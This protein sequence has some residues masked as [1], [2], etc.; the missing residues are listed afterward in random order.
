MVFGR[1]P[2]GSGT[3]LAALSLLAAPVA[4]AEP[5][6]FRRD[7]TPLPSAVSHPASSDAAQIAG[8]G[9]VLLRTLVGLVIVVALIYGVYWLLKTYAGSK[10]GKS[11]GRMDIV[12]TTALAPS[13]ALHLVQVGD[14]LIL[15]GSADESITPIR[16]YSADESVLLRARMEGA[17]APFRPARGFGGGWASFVTQMRARTVRR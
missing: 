4:R 17:P 11:D 16:L 2:T 14:E 9:G 1:P 7:Q 8:S 5:N 12:A 6:A 10:G 3:V 15:I 13:R